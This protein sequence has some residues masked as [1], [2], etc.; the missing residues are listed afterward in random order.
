MKHL[1]KTVQDFTNT[2]NLNAPPE[3]RT[4][5]LVSEVGEVAKEILKM[6]NYGTKEPEHREEIK[7]ELGDLLFSLTA[8]ANQLDVDLEDAL[9]LVLDKYDKRLQKGSAGSEVE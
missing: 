3:H 1:Q 2:H 6:T 8:L 5:D 9:Q 7:G 4:L